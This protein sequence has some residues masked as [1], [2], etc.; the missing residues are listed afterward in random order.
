[1]ARES[2]DWWFDVR[3]KGV[4]RRRPR[5]IHELFSESS[6][7]SCTSDATTARWYEAFESRVTASQ[8]ARRSEWSSPS[9]TKPRLRGSGRSGVDPMRARE[10]HRCRRSE[11][12]SV[13]RHCFAWKSRNARDAEG[14]PVGR[15]HESAFA[16]GYDRPKPNDRSA[17][18]STLSQTTN[19]P[20]AISI[21]ISPS[22]S[23]VHFVFLSW[24]LVQSHLQA[25]HR[26]F[27]EMSAH[28]EGG[29]AKS[30]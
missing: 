4:G 6:E 18:W 1:M 29:G 17:P 30:K 20:T 19:V 10:I 3:P 16:G 2:E 25:E 9:E 28:R 14:S 15:E 8:P 12:G 23:P 5:P 24:K 7:T 22:V 13:G 11:R 27:H 21:P 26:Q